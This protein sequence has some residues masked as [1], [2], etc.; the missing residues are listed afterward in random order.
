MGDTY[1][2]GWHRDEEWLAFHNAH[3]KWFDDRIKSYFKD[4]EEDE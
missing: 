3:K 4:V 2:G 1:L